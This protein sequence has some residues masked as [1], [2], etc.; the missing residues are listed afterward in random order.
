MEEL[1]PVVIESNVDHG[2]QKEEK[3]NTFVMIGCC[4]HQ[5]IATAGYEYLK[6]YV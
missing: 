5:C 6:E 2:R 3:V 1:E 4:V